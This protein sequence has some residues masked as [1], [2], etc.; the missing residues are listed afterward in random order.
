MERIWASTDGTS[1]LSRRLPSDDLALPSRRAALAALRP[2]IEAEG[3]PVLVTGEPGVGKSWLWRRLQAEMG[4]PWRWLVVDVPPGIDPPALYR[5]IGHGLGIPARAQDARCHG[6]EGERLDAADFLREASADGQRWILVLDEAHNAS[7]ELLEDVRV[8]A[9][10]LGRPDGFSAMILVGQTI[11]AGRLAVRPLRALASRLSAHVHLRGLDADEARTMID[12]LAPGTRWDDRTLERHHR[13]AAGNPRRLLRLARAVTA[14]A[15]S[16]VPRRQPA[17]PPKGTDAT[18][19]VGTVEDW[20]SSLMTPRKPPLRVGDGMIEVG[21]EPEP[22]PTVAAGPPA[23]IPAGPYSAPVTMPPLDTHGSPVPALATGRFDDDNGDSESQADF[24]P[25]HDPAA[26]VTGESLE[27]VN[28]P[29]A[30]LQAWDEWNRNQE[31]MAARD[32]SPHHAGSPDDARSPAG[33]D[34]EIPGPSHPAANVRAEAHQGFAPYSQLFS[35]L[36]QN[37]DP[38]EST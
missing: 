36:R 30:A 19:I 38:N 4:R 3:G 17:T 31:R 8:L 21:W 33:L 37:L 10:R 27:A 28:D 24:P 9:N 34:D 11:L 15:T 7:A 13:D 22:G 2:T 18:G 25:E 16:S 32:T 12:L 35:R 6:D 14:S 23:E 1:D 20:G 5:L 26:E 29:Y